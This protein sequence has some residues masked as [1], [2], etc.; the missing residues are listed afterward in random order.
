SKKLRIAVLYESWFK[1][2]NAIPPDWQKAGSWKIQNN[3][4]CGDDS[5][6][7][8]AINPNVKEELIGNLKLFSNELPGSVIQTGEYLKK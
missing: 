2:S 3:F 6:S 8:F 5:V 1:D 7:I 4:I